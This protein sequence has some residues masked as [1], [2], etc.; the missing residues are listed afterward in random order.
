MT[1]VLKSLPDV[2]EVRAKALLTH[3]GT[4]EAI[5]KASTEDLAK[6]DGISKRRAERLFTLFHERYKGD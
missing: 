3:F 6:V 2:G 4:L 1:Y 5:F